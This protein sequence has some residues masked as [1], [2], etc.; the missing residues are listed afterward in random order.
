MSRLYHKNM[1]RLPI[2]RQQKSTSALCQSARPYIDHSS[3]GLRTTASLDV[4][5]PSSLRNER[6]IYS[7][8][9]E[10]H[11][12]PKTIKTWPP[13]SV[14]GDCLHCGDHLELMYPAAKYK[15]E[16]KFWVFG[17]FCSPG[18]SLG[19]VR[20]MGMGC[21]V[22]TWTRSMLS[23]VFSVTSFDVCPPRFC[24]K[25]YGGGMEKQVWKDINFASLVEPPLS[26]FAMF[27][28]AVAREK[29]ENLIPNSVRLVNIQRPEKRDVPVAT[30]TCNGRE[31]ILLKL[32]AEACPEPEEE[33]L[34][35]KPQ[36]KKTRKTVKT[37]QMLLECN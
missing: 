25:R 6:A 21:Q 35:V 30:P 36:A 20:E 31:P 27:A 17:Q 29:S 28:E 9:K 15:A 18:C 5:Y 1:S 4:V 33:E 7:A 32:L 3:E 26:T 2:S 37:S 12:Q 34:A 23:Q 14:E 24:L 22:E 11:T 16:T 8:G 13:S 19:Y 10:A